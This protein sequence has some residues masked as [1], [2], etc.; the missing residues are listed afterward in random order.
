MIDPDGARRTPQYRLQEVFD[1][2]PVGMAI[3]QPDG[4]ITAANS[5]L[6]EILHYPATQLVGR[7]IGEL[8]HP[9]DAATLRAAY[10]GLIDGKPAPFRS[11]AKLLAP[12]EDTVLV[13][14][15][16]SVLCDAQDSPTHH[17]TMVEDFT[18]RQLLEQRVRHQSLH[19]LLTGLPNRLHFAIHLEAL[20]ERDRKA[21]VMLCKIDLDGFGVVNDG[22]GLGIGD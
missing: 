12:N 7:D 6:T 22:L 4:T 16:V 18:D 1:S 21:A 15:T 13:A 19:D 17:I 9:D 10:Q 14:L 20:L 2:A 8:F 3:S 5:A 11:R